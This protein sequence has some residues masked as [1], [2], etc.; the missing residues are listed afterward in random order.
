MNQTKAIVCN[1][2]DWADLNKKA[3]PLMDIVDFY[4][5]ENPSKY[6]DNNKCYGCFKEIE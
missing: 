1:K 6:L 3:Y 5:I 2:C 4:K